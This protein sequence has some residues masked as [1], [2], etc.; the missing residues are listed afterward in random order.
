[1]KIDAFLMLLEIEKNHNSNIM[2][3]TARGDDK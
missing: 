1:M 3:P 2:H